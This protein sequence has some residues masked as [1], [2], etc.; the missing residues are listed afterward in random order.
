MNTNTKKLEKKKT[1]M[2][3]SVKSRLY[4]K[5]GKQDNSTSGRIIIPIDETEFKYIED[6]G[7]KMI[8]LGNEVIKYVK[9]LKDARKQI[10][11]RDYHIMWVSTA[12]FLN[13]INEHETKEK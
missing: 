8:T 4:T 9:N 7:K 6:D 2:W 1:G 5:Q 10:R 3:E 11:K 13:K 12:I